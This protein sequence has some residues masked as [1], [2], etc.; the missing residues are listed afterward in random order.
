MAAI[1]KGQALTFGTGTT[2]TLITS[3]T[4]N[5]NSSKKEI[6]NG[7]GGFGAVVYYAVKDE[8]SLET[9][10][11]DDPNTGDEVE[12]PGLIAPFV[13]GLVIVTAAESIESSEDMTKRNLTAV[14]YAQID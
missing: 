13:S 3:A 8:V 12:L 1:I 4:V 2:P 14:A 10:A 11:A 7:A 6:A 5:R 9:Y